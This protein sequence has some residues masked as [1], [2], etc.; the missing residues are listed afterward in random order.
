MT[1]SHVPALRRIPSAAEAAAEIPALPFAPIPR[2]DLL[3]AVDTVSNARNGGVLLICAPAGTGKT[4]LLADWATRHTAGEPD[5][6]WLTLTDEFDDAAALWTALHARFGI[7]TA[8]HGGPPT[9]DAAALVDALATRATPT[10]VVLDDA[11]LLSDPVAL[12]GVEYF[13]HHA[14]PTVTTVLCARFAPP[15]RWH[16]LDLQSRLT[17]WNRGDL[18]FTSDQI[19]A[20]CRDHGCELTDAELDTLATLTHGW[21]ALVRIAAAHLAARSDDRAVALSILT[22]PP[23]AVAE[24]LVGELIDGLS[25]SLRQFL[26]YTS[27]P[28]S[29]T[30]QLADELVGGGA[31]HYLH[32]LDR[33]NFPLS[34][35][36]RGDDVW[37]AC[38]PM[39]RAYFLAEAQ[40]LGPQLCADLHGQSARWLRSADLPATALPHFLADPDRE[41]LCEFLSDCALRMVLDGAGDTLFDGLAQSAPTLLDDPFL[42]LVRVVDALVR[43]STAAA[44]ACL[45]TATARRATKASF[46]SDERVE[47]LALAA[48]IDVAATTGTE[49]GEFRDEIAPTGNPDLDA[50]AAI[51]VATG[52]VA[53]GAVARGEQ[54]LH[55]SLALAE[56]AGR[57]R[58]VLRALTRLALAANAVDAATAM[59]DRAAHALTIAGAHRL[60]DATDAVQA[61]A[62]AAYGAYLQG[63]TPDPAQVSAVLAEHVDH[64]GSSGPVAGWHGQ[65]IGRLLDLEHTEEPS[66]AV[67]ALRRSLLMLVEHRTLPSATGNLI[68]PVV[69]ALLRVHDPRTAQLLVERA[70]GIVGDLPEIRMADAALNAAAD[71]PKATCAILE[72]LLHNAIDLRPVSAIT[73]W[74]LYS[75]AQHEAGAPAKAV[76]ALES[77]LNAAAPQRLIRPFLDMPAALPLLDSYAGRFGRSE[78]F[79]AIIRRHPAVHRRSAYPALTR[80]EMIVLKQLPSG[81]TAQQIAADLGV[82]VNTV[83]TH[84]RGIYGKLGSNSRVDAL[85]HARRGGLL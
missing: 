32:E 29:F 70:R 72:P 26:I 25:P 64:D 52:L 78:R 74:L 65:V 38:H 79:A 77:A 31:G 57:P 39:V 27:I 8:E 36:S 37:Y 47:A 83:K 66:A 5:V 14:P 76:V 4:V 2:T 80:T 42:W 45:D 16:I 21:A 85:E 44:V 30:G 67:E 59:R 24:F 61:T 69:W 68:L 41:N 1:T 3:A 40:R 62:V 55:S 49:L 46:A 58:L 34:A 7:A 33:I 15:I 9:M 20:L 73:G 19:D 10:V 48:T 71:R 75:S 84:L 18:A 17:R 63:E 82:S 56:H 50:Y 53:R 28:V 13:L 60:L 54:L 51:Q 6:A 35:D 23:R 81:R 22:R 11:H 12:A 43:G